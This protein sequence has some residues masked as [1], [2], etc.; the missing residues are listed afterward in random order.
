MATATKK[1]SCLG[2]FPEKRAENSAWSLF[3]HFVFIAWKRA[4]ETDFRTNL[5]ASPVH[6]ANDISPVWSH[7]LSTFIV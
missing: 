7:A 2:K 5:R 1:K 3:C 6:M 4:L